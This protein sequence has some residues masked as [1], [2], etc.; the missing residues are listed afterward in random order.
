MAQSAKLAT[1]HEVDEQDLSFGPFR[2]QGAKRLW[3]GEQV[4]DV[5]PR[6]LAVLRYLAERPGRLVTREE[7][8]KRLW[9][10][11]SV[12]KTVLRVC[13]REI[14]QALHDD[15]HEPQ[16]LDTV[17]RQGY[18]F[19]GTV[20][21]PGSRVQSHEEGS[22]WNLHLGTSL[23]SIQAPSYT[24]PVLP[25]VGR[26][27]ELARLWA[28]YERVQCGERQMVLLSG[29]AGIGKTTVIDR[30]LERVRANRQVRIG[31][32]QCVEHHGPGEA[33][34]PLLEVL[35]QLC[36]EPGGSHVLALLR[37]HAPLWLA[38]LLGAEEQGKRDVEPHQGQGGT[39]ERM[40]RELAEA[41][42]ALAEDSVV[43]VVLEDFHWSDVSTLEAVAYL[44]Q[45]RRPA[46]LYM[47]GAY[48]P[49]EAVVREHPLRGMVQELYGRRQCE[50][51]ALELLTEAEVETFLTQ[52]FGLSPTT[53]ALSELI[54]QRTDGN[55]LFMA[56]FVAYLLERELVMVTDGQMELRIAS[57]ALRELVPATLQQLIA[58]EIERLPEKEQQFLTLASVSGPTFTAAEVAGVLGKAVEGVEE[59]YDSLASAGRLIEDAGIRQWP[60]GM[61]T[62]RYAFRHV[63]YQQVLYERI[64]RGRRI[65]PHHQTR[66]WEV[67]YGEQV[68]EIAGEL[69][70]HCTEG[71]DYGQAVRYHGQAGESALRCSTY[72][73][74]I[75]HCKTGLELLEW[76]PNTAEYQRQE[77]ALRMLLLAALLMIRGF[78]IEGLT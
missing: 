26:E 55:P 15:L 53:T 46:Q 68:G 57:S 60:D 78:G 1:Q 43:A 16:Y 48:R 73:E 20:Q 13:V 74:V 45:R 10:G 33:Y 49:V 41:L 18:R 71:Q 28:V 12:T 50:E 7:L 76:L 27:Q 36:R 51:I 31:R 21:R 75:E 8:L 9:P 70:E 22:D 42:E 24:S 30:F 61:I 44:A 17:G 38:Q 72:R 52:C 62:A 69:A 67:G 56:H 47:I 65:R 66:Q 2:L 34:L 23:A 3:R 77:L 6:P 32:G 63:L 4:V 19:I 40:L 11:I 35:G 29:E 58:Q 25:F 64:G 54:Y 59:V 14:R 39:G 37:R 5:R